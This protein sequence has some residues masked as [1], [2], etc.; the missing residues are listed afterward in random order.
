[1]KLTRLI[2]VPFSLIAIT[3]FLVAG[4]TGEGSKVSDQ[5]K[6]AFG[7]SS[8]PA[9]IVNGHEIT[10][11]ALN[12]AVRN[13]ALGMGQQEALTEELISKIA[14]SVLDQMITGELLFQAGEKEGFAVSDQAV[15]DAFTSISTQYKAA[16]EFQAEMTRRG[17]TEETLKKDIYRQLTIR[18]FI[19]GTIA[20]KIEVTEAAARKFFKENPE[21]FKTPE[22]TKASHILIKTSADDSEEARETARKKAQDI[23]DKARKKG[24]DFAELARAN[25]EGPSGPKGGEL[26][27][28]GKGQMVK[29]FEEAAFSMKIGQ[30]SD[31][32]LTEFGYHIIKVTDRKT[33][34][35]IPFEQVSQRIMASLKNG[36][37]NKQ[38]GDKIKELSSAADI[39]VKL[40][41]AQTPPIPGQEGSIPRTQ[42]PH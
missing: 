8:G 30:I 35:S 36:E 6:G 37:I 19:E 17:F 5:A 1:M 12:T 23:A 7:T 24:A 28:F 10:F 21:K 20:S 3:L 27:F 9:A 38:I 4:C 29:A 14:P 31:P 13:A 39:E 18:K 26:G 22:Q 41:P 15:V 33:E 11:E 2:S 40:Q 16:D 25:S 32:I 34:S 42:S